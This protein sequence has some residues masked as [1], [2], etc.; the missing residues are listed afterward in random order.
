[1]HF[2]TLGR[3]ETLSDVKEEDLVTDT[4]LLRLSVFQGCGETLLGAK[5][6]TLVTDTLL[7]PPVFQEVP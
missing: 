1:M 7:F 3:R 5:G 6:E 2:Y 4:V